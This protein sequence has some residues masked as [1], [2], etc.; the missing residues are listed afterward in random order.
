MTFFSELPGPSGTTVRLLNE[1]LYSL[2]VNGRPIAAAT[3]LPEQLE[4]F[5]AGYLITEGIT[6]YS[7]IES[8]MPYT[9]VIGV[10]TVNPFKVLLPKKQ[11]Y[12]AAEGLRHI[13]ILRGSP[14]FPTV[15]VCLCPVSR[16]IFRQR[17]LRQEDL[18]P[19][20]IRRPVV[21][22]LHQI[23]ASMPHST[24]SSTRS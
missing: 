12:R 13:L 17:F 20:H 6:A 18:P 23:S 11:W 2:T 1:Q 15:I 3:L 24:K 8:I 14:K 9:A 16:L 19:P 10:L 4:E 22:H 7:E 21:S 5:A